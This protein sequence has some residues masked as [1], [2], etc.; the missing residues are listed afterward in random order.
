MQFRTI[1]CSIAQLDLPC[2]ISP[3]SVLEIESIRADRQKGQGQEPI[4]GE[5]P[6][7]GGKCLVA[8]SPPSQPVRLWLREFVGQVLECF[9]DLPLLWIGQSAR[10]IGRPEVSRPIGY[11]RN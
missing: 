2:P 7:V 10:S 3:E 8:G 9:E 1:L 4:G 5:S 6:M 11:P